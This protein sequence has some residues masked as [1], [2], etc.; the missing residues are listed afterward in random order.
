MARTRYTQKP[1]FWYCIQYTGSNA[2]EM[3]EFCPRCVYNA[4]D[5][6]LY[7]NL[8]LVEPMNWMLEDQAGGFS[9]MSDSQFNAFF[10][11]SAGGP[12]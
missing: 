11:L 9:M 2:T 12:P 1:L 3:V 7:F 4:G 5:Q 6:K 8:V 10:Q